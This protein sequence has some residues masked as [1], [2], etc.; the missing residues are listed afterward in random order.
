ME[1]V[2]SLVAVESV[3]RGV[4]SKDI[5]DVLLASQYF[6]SVGTR[7]FSSEQRLMLAVLADAIN[8]LWGYRVS[9]SRDKR[10]PLNEALSWVFANGIASPLSFDHVCDALG[11]H[12][13]SLRRRL[14]E[15]VSEDSGDL[16]KLRRKEGGRR[17]GPIINHI[18]RR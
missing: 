8:A 18:R 15:S 14:S 10:N 9:A 2:K 3:R 7:T 16:P 5:P 17:R 12:A 4:Y 1:S 11:L 13:E 6:E